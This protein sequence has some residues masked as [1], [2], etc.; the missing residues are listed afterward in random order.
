MIVKFI[1]IHMIDY[2]VK[3]TGKATLFTY[4]FLTQNSKG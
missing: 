4:S 3:K 1:F 2:Y